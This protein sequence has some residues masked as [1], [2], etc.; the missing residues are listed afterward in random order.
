MLLPRKVITNKKGPTFLKIGNTA[1]SFLQLAHMDYDPA[2]E[3]DLNG[4]K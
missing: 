3:Y 4:N 2:A 1:Q